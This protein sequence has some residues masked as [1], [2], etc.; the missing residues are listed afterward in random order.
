M[1]SADGETSHNM[2]QHDIALLLADAA[3]EVK[4]GIAPAQALIRGGRRRKARRW[5]VVA[6]TTLV[7]AGST[8]ALAL[9]GLSGDG[10]RGVSPA[11]RPV[12]SAET[13]EPDMRTT[14]A[15]GTDAGAP[16]RVYIDVWKAPADTAEAQ[17]TLAA[18]AKF[19]E[20]PEDVS[21]AS[22]L[23]GKVA[24]FVHRVTGEEARTTQI[25]DMV[26]PEDDV[27]SGGEYGTVSLPLL[28]GNGTAPRLVI[29]QVAKTAREVTCTWKDGT[30]TKVG[31]ASAATEANAAV[32][33]IHSPKHSPYDWFVCLAPKS[34][35]YEGIKVTK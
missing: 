35:A 24:H 22:E 21:T 18:M 7:L 14:L 15:S 33:V 16:W 31:R 17:A 10:D 12:A 1:N 19:G 20:H 30:S 29:G 4:I 9:T 13:S 6:T 11:S 32:P 34:T 28:P 8:G 27:L 5:A 25:A 2:T 23:V 26:L 3:D